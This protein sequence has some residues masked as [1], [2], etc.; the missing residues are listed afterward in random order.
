MTFA[1][2]SISNLQMPKDDLFSFVNNPKIVILITVWMILLIIYLL[3]YIPVILWLTKSIKQAI[4]WDKITQKENI[5]YWFKNLNNSFKTYWYIFAYVALIPSI[6]FIIWWLF[7]NM[8]YYLK[9]LDL[10]KSIWILFMVLWWIIFAVFS[11]YRW[12]KSTFALYSAVNNESFT[13]QDFTKS[14]E[15]TKN[16]WW[17]MIWNFLLIWLIIWLL[18]SLISWVLWFATS[19]SI[20]YNN[21]KSIDDIKAIAWNFNTI[22]TSLSGFISTILNTFWTVFTIVFTYLFY[23]RMKGESDNSNIK[24]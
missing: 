6:L 17:R 5:I 4:N 13:K 22:S 14:L 7:F 24:L 23:L 10:F 15:I 18:S 16:N 19:N 11:I 9:D 21:I 1:L 20:N 8:W 2:S 12:I 3:L